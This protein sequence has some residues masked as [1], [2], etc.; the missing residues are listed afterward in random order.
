[1]NSFFPDDPKKLKARIRSYERAL[2]EDDRDG[3]GKRYLLGPMY[4][5][6]GDVDGALRH[7][8]WFNKIYNDDCGEP[9]Q[10]LCWTLAL[11][12]AG[13]VPEAIQKFK[14]TM[15]QNLYLIPVVLGESPRELDIW[16]SS[17]FCQLSYTETIPSELLGL[18]DDGAKRWAKQLWDEETVTEFRE[19]YIDIES[20]LKGLAPGPTRSVLVKQSFE[21]RRG[22]TPLRLVQ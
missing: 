13:K 4:L 12:K 5:L 2:S 14:Q 18:W 16:H 17:N 3:A 9:F 7:F 20:Q 10:Y 21:M 6:L 19:R 8:E 11:Y 15:L 1:M 22:I